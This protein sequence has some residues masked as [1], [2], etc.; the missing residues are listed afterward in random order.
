LYA[1]YTRDSVAAMDPNHA[2]TLALTALA[3]ALVAGLPT[4]VRAARMDLNDIMSSEY[5]LDPDPVER[6][7]IV[8]DT[9]NSMDTRGSARTPAWFE[10]FALLETLPHPACVPGGVGRTP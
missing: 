10:Y 6:S 1:G 2:L 8:L 4:I 7:R 3:A 5:A 9:L